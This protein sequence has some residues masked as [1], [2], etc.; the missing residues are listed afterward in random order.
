MTPCRPGRGGDRRSPAAGSRAQ[1]G[2][3]LRLQRSPP[4]P[5]PPSHVRHSGLRGAEGDGAPGWGEPGEAWEPPG[6]VSRAAV[7]G[8]AVSASGGPPEE[9]PDLTHRPRAGG[10]LQEVQLPVLTVAPPHTHT[11]C[12][13]LAPPPHSAS[14]LEH[15][16]WGGL[17]LHAP[18]TTA[19]AEWVICFSKLCLL[20][21]SLAA[22]R[23]AGLAAVEDEEF[24]EG[25]GPGKR[26][27]CKCSSTPLPPKQSRV[28]ENPIR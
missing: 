18:A 6:Q 1:G 7:P 26:A 13:S 23:Q 16:R 24:V 2:G 10:G 3:P 9:R 5:P 17:L 14:L 4:T 8:N 25:G 28:G 11:P 22:R 12:R 19:T 21:R 20:I 27:V 15:S